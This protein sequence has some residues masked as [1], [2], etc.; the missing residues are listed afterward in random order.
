MWRIYDC[1]VYQHDFRLLAIAA[2]ICLFGTVTT[3]AITAR[4]LPA[5]RQQAT[6]LTLAGFC[7][8]A[9]IWSTHFVAILAYR[10]HLPFSFHLA[11]T[12]G[13]L[14]FGI[15]VIVIGFAINSTPFGQRTAGIVGGLIIGT[16]VA[17]LHFIGMTALHLPGRISF[18]LELA[19]A[20]TLMSLGFGALSSWVFHRFTG[21]AR[22][23]TSMACFVLM[24]L[25][26]HFVGMS[27]VNIDLRLWEAAQSPAISRE[28]LAIIVSAVTLSFVSISLAAALFDRRRSDDL[29]I[30]ARRFRL[31]AN[32]VLEGLVV[33]R[34]G[35]P[36]DTNAAARR[37]MA[38]DTVADHGQILNWFSNADKEQVQD[39]LADT[40]EALIEAEMVAFDGRQ[41][42]V[43]FSCQH[44][45]LEDG[46]EGQIL[47]F[48]DVT[49]RKQAEEM[50]HHQALHDPLTNLANRRLFE[51]LAEK[52]LADARRSGTS[53]A[54]FAIDLDN[55]KMINDLHGHIGGDTVLIE[56]A[57]RIDATVRGSDIVAR[58]GGD[59]FALVETSTKAP[60]D[61]SQL[62]ARLIEL[63]AGPVQLEETAVAVAAS[64]G[65]A[66]Y[67]TDGTTIAELMHNADTAMYR[68]KSDGKGT[69]R[70][71][72]PDMNHALQI[73]R[74]L[75]RRL[76]NA[77]ES[78]GISVAYQP[79][80]N[81]LTRQAEGFEALGRWTDG[82]LGNVPPGDFIP[83]AEEAG[84]IVNLS[85]QILRKA[86]LEAMTWPDD[87]RVA[88]NLSAVQFRR[89]G[90][91]EKV[92]E[93]L[94]QTGLP[95]SR[96]ELEITE[97]TLIDNREQVLES[98]RQIK[99]LGVSI[100]MDDFG[101]GYSSLSYLQSFPFDKI[102]IDRA[103]VAQLDE[104]GRNHS[105][106][107]AIAA[108]GHSMHMKV[109]AEGV[110]TEM[111]AKAVA[112]MCCDELQG[113]L[114][115]RP[116]A[117]EAVLD[118]LRVNRATVNLPKQV[119]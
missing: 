55:F 21:A 57:S 81:S 100:A 56:V 66:I 80:V 38:L 42:P 114:V 97:S 69:F 31:M 15:V 27:S 9:S 30:Q 98:L 12:L 75:E 96:L 29:E 32:K 1:L 109:V 34:H 70:F 67:P 107:N 78:D 91:A 25:S 45:E 39:W 112:E 62:A 51:E 77:I 89:P 65:I 99:S 49:A 24:V 33:H 63:A 18:D 119:A 36:I 72:T 50:L 106:I 26:L 8:A 23:G 95:G 82:E 108:M 113:Y 76:R 17:G 92:A 19:T 5:K 79:I 14:A 44:H 43:E 93:V 73:R 58:L 87:L 60:R 3:Y 111:Q 116:M 54:V 4:A 103:F 47:A 90:F 115:A 83:V 53:F 86:C 20:A 40:G 94:Q 48:R 6:W 110:E 37:L 88:V 74:K 101:T 22:W 13:S 84:L 105:I 117:P 41:F 85:E 35:T 11:P 64:I 7:A 104:D 2:A 46:S 16:G 28:T 52:V 10:E 59:E 118:F 68:S 61:A 102:K 71:F